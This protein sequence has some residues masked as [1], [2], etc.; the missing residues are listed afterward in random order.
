VT[1]PFD[2]IIFVIGP[3][4]AR[5]KAYADYLGLDP[6]RVRPVSRE[7]ALRGHSLHADQVLIA[8]GTE[9]SDQMRASLILATGVLR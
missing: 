5:C 6:Q 7:P 8:P 9:L 3:S 4:K 2:R 1:L